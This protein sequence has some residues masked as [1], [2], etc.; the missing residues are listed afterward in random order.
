MAAAIATIL[1]KGAAYY[2]TGSVGLLSDALE[3]L[4][5]LAGAL[6]AFAMLT[7]AARPADE[8]HAFGHN[9]AEYFSSG[10]EGAL[11]LLAAIGIII[12]ALPRLISP[13]PL[14]KL[15]TGLFLALGASLINGAVAMILLRAGRRFGSI[16]LEADARHLLTDVWTSLGVLAGIAAVALTGWLRFDAIVALLV[17]AHIVRSGLHIV[18]ESIHGLMD[19]ALPEEEVAAIR[20]IL[21]KYEAD[22]IVFHALKTRRAGVRRFATLHVL[23]PGHWS[24]HRGHL[25]LEEMEQKLRAALPN[26]SVLTH[27][28]SLEDMASFDDEGHDR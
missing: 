5:N 15:G 17:A 25:L 3:S 24:V 13:A 19:T 18:T 28:E 16:V 22:G 9:K 23:V 20:G 1:L 27:L 21:Q 2:F 11:I 10:V 14:Q 6:M 7:V 8:E 4:V 26:L 12:T